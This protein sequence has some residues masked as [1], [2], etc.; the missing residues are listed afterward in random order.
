[1]K[2]FDYLVSVSGET[3]TVYFSSEAKTP[4]EALK[5]ASVETAGPCLGP[6]DIEDDIEIAALIAY[7]FNTAE[8]IS[9]EEAAERI[10]HLA[11]EW[12]L[13]PEVLSYMN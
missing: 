2:K 11:E 12:G 8:E 10:A 13:T 9:A 5:T 7:K 1:M 3:C 6:A 4:E